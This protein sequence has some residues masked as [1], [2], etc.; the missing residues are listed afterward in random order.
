M[1]RLAVTLASAA[2]VLS[3]GSANALSAG[4]K[5]RLVKSVYVY[6][7]YEDVHDKRIAKDA[8]RAYLHDQRYADRNFLAFQSEVPAGT[9]VTIKSAVARRWWTPWA[10]DRYLVELTPDHAKGLEVE[11]SLD[12]GME[13]D[14][15]GLNRSIF[16]RER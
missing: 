12:R 4:D 9:M 6:A 1:R 8:A 16:Q 5:Y 3:V 2:L 13:G 10:A 7:V 15:D 11:L 14:L